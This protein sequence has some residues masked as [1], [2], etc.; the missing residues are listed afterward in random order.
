[1]AAAMAWQSSLGSGRLPHLGNTPGTAS[2]TIR[3]R[4]IMRRALYADDPVIDF[5]WRGE[6]PSPAIDKDNFYVRWTRQMVLEP[7]LYRFTVVA[8]DRI[9]L[10]AGSALLMDEWR[11]HPLQPFVQEY[12]HGGGSVTV[13]LEYYE[14][15]GDAAVKLDRQKVDETVERNGWR[16]EYYN[17]EA[18]SGSPGLIRYE[19]QVD[20]NWST[21]APAQGVRADSF[22]TGFS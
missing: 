12:N 21:G 6:S 3:L 19:P 7:G 1:M 5:D 17:N 13:V 16:A 18:L 9:R 11:S 10:R 22:S 8:D 4:W 2:T 14:D 20:F 15:T